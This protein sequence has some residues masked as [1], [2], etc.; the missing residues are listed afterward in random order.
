M[1]EPSASLAQ[2]IE[3]YLLAEP[4]WVHAAEICRVFNLTSDRAMRADKDR[5]GL[6]SA[7][8]ISST[9]HGFKHIRHAT[10]EEFAD[11]YHRLRG[12]GLGELVAARKLLRAR[13]S[14]VTNPPHPEPA[15]ERSTGNYL[16]PV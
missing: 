16:L 6:L 15:L 8:A 3:E 5:P 11:A 12:H 9:G 7:F 14:A 13:K 2:R 1:S 10:D 4:R